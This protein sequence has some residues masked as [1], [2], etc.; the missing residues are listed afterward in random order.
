MNLDNNGNIKIITL[1]VSVLGVGTYYLAQGQEI[2][3]T[4]TSLLTSIPTTIEKTY[5][6]TKERYIEQPLNSLEESKKGIEQLEIISINKKQEVLASS[7]KKT[8]DT[9]PQSKASITV[10]D[11]E[12]SKLTNQMVEN[13]RSITAEYDK[14]HQK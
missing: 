14:L 2:K 7:D 10:N 12:I 5:I 11:P 13:C 8:L 4:S 9:L 3:G 6:E 1:L